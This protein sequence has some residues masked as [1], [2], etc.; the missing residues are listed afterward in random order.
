[1]KVTDPVERDYLQKIEF[2]V[3][4]CPPQFL[5]ISKMNKQVE[6]IIATT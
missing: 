5:R 4:N 1:M 3:K 2:A 6:R